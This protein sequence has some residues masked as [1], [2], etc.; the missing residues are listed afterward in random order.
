MNTTNAVVNQHINTAHTRN[1]NP[2]KC[3]SQDKQT[4]LIETSELTMNLKNIVAIGGETE[5][6]QLKIHIVL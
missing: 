2:H 3:D 5:Q 1:K 6:T 4:S